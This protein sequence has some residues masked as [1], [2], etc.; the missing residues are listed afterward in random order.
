MPQPL[1]VAVPAVPAVLAVLAALA[2][3]AV[4]KTPRFSRR[5]SMRLRR[6]VETYFM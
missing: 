5:L 6:D 4:I 2:E 3:A 1:V